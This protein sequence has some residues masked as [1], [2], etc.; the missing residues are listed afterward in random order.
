MA[1]L[2]KT[3]T[4]TERQE[5]WIKSQID[6]GDY[7]NDSEYLRDLIRNDQIN[8]EK[9]ALLRHAL[10]EGEESGISKRSMTDILAD[11]KQRNNVT[12]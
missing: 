10:I 9:L 11:A 7:G 8:K 4:V 1:M 12:T 3:I 5:S 2:R 6:S